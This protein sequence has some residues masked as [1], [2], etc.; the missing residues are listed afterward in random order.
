L[1]DVKLVH[2]KDCIEMY[3]HILLHF[4]TSYKPSR[5]L[6][7]VNKLQAENHDCYSTC[8]ITKPLDRFRQA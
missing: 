1:N 5:S 7:V 8:C 2:C 3:K 6:V 4:K